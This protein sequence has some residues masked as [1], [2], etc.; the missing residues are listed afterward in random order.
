[1]QITGTQ[2]SGMSHGAAYG[3]DC[4]TDTNYP[5]VRITNLKTKH[6]FY[7]RTH[8]HSS[9]AVQ[10]KLSSYTFFDVPTTVELGPSVLEVVASGIPSL[11]TSITVVATC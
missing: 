9:V 8:D 5:L 11:P 6:V 3:D 2:M 1:M 4:Q 7:C 10:S